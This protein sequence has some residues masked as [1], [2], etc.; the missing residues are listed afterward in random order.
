MLNK[1]LL[2]GNLV[3]DPELRSTPS[4]TNVARMRLAC[5]ERYKSKVTGE[6]KEDTLFVTLDVWGKQANT[7]QQYLH[8]G[9]RIFV[10]GKL[11]IRSYDQDGIRK[12]FT[13]V[14]VSR[15]I[16]L[17]RKQGGDGEAGTGSSDSQRTGE[18][19]PP[20]FD[21]DDIPFS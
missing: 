10:E 18:N 17:D 8:K 1:V 9:S 13:S 21:E 20:E 14:T 6:L 2:I 11:R 12:W 3:D 15:F 7:A 16:F 5:N 19:D 4:G